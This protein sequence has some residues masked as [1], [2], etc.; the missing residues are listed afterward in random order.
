MKGLFGLLILVCLERRALARKTA[1]FVWKKMELTILFHSEDCNDIDCNPGCFVA[2][3]RDL[4]LELS[5][6]T[7]NSMCLINSTSITNLSV[8]QIAR[9]TTI[10]Q[11]DGL[12]FCGIMDS[13]CSIPSDI[14]SYSCE[15]NSV[16]QLVCNLERI[17]P[18][19]CATVL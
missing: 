16:V 8:N 6:E 4:T 17:S 2:Q 10:S 14:I 5:L 11:Y 3:E 15:D 7:S 12:I 18:T 9:V 13:T 1:P 19:N